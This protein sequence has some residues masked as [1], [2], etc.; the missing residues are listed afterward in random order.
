MPS[1][2]EGHAMLLGEREIEEKYGEEN[3]HHTQS[4]AA[5]PVGERG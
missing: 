3:Y 1:L 2:L 4:E 5:G